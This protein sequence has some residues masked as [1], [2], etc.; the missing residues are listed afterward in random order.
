MS[1][2]PG[3]RRRGSTL[4]LVTGWV[5]TVGGLILAIPFVPGPGF[6]LLLGG[7]ALLSSESRWFRGLLRRYREHLLMKQ[8]LRAAERAGVKIDLDAGS[9][10]DGE[11]RNAPRDR[12]TGSEG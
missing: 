12:A 11:T 1:G 3:G 6:I 5:L 2:T 7:V 9:P 4:R 8:A 10:G